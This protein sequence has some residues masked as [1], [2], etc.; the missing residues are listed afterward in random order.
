MRWAGVLPTPGIA[1]VTRRLEADCGICISASHNP[2]ADNG[3]KLFGSDG[4]KWS[5]EVETSLEK[6]LQPAAFTES[7][8]APE[9]EDD[10]AQIYLRE[11]WASIEGE[12]SSRPLQGLTVALD[13]ANGAASPFARQL[14]EH[15]GAETHSFHDRPDGRNINENCG[16]THEAEIVRLVVNKPL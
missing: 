11:L 1:L 7:A 15:L 6:K 13:C 16:S 2:F 8:T 9:V 5:T 4:F 12:A 14:F 10:L 3:I